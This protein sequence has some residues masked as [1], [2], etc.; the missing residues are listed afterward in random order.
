MKTKKENKN[1]TE[2]TLDSYYFET[3]KKKSALYISSLY[4]P[5]MCIADGHCA[6]LAARFLAIRHVIDKVSRNRPRAEFSLTLY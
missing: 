6:M 1:I 4:I 5:A 3:Y 2:K